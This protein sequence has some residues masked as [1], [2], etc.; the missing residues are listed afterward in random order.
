V[1]WIDA[2][3]VA[4]PDRQVDR[5]DAGGVHPDQDDVR[6]DRWLRE[7]VAQAQ[8]ALVAEPVVGD[9]PQRRPFT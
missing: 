4:P 7:V 1:V 9:T 3:Q 8:D 2:G 5:V 6:A